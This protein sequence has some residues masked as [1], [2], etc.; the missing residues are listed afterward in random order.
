[1]HD[2]PAIPPDQRTEST[3]KK[4]SNP[5]EI[6]LHER[7][8]IDGNAKLFF[9]TFLQKIKA[10]NPS[11]ACDEQNKP[12]L[13]IL[14]KL[15]ADPVYYED[16]NDKLPPKQ[17]CPL[18]L[19]FY[20]E[21]GGKSQLDRWIEFYSNIETKQCI[22]MIA[23]KRYRDSTE[24]NRLLNLGYEMYGA[25]WP[26]KQ[27]KVI[28]KSLDMIQKDEQYGELVL[29]SVNDLDHLLAWFDDDGTPHRYSTYSNIVLLYVYEL[30]STG[31]C[32]NEKMMAERYATP[33]TCVLENNER[34]I[35]LADD[36][37]SEQ[38][39]LWSEY[40]KNNIFHPTSNFYLRNGK[41]PQVDRIEWE[42]GTVFANLWGY[43]EDAITHHKIAHKT[44]GRNRIEAGHAG[45]LHFRSDG[46]LTS[47][48]KYMHFLLSNGW[49]R[50]YDSSVNDVMSCATGKQEELLRDTKLCRPVKEIANIMAIVHQRRLCLQAGYSEEHCMND[51]TCCVTEPDWPK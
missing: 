7:L 4:L 36:N 45:V 41:P 39:I 33:C 11:Q 18:L 31:I 35:D 21:G 38:T 27:D 5:L 49:M 24:I 19:L 14:K 34:Y 44:K 23:P 42:T 2:S 3:L 47:T 46:Y 10:I 26:V 28:S 50:D 8:V 30:L 16:Y 48:T 12:Y 9:S 1:M 6:R 40:G 22:K 51:L 25:D 37:S 15:Q 20:V 29:V 13:N 32:P 17:N 43:D